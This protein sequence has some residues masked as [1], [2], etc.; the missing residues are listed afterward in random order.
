VVESRPQGAARLSENPVT[1][2]VRVMIYLPAAIWYRKRR[3]IERTLR[4][5][6]GE[7]PVS[8]IR[9]RKL[10]RQDWADRWKQD[11]DVRKVGRRIVIVPSWKSYAPKRNEIAITMDPG[12]AFG[13]GL[14]PTTRLCLI[15][16][17]KYLRIGNRVLDVGTGSGILAIAS[18][19]LGANSIDA[20]DIETAAIEAAGRNGVANGIADRTRLHLGTLKE[21][22]ATIPTADL[23]LVNILAYTIIRILPELKSKLPT[24][25]LLVTGG[26]LAEFR[27][28]VE[29]ALK[30]AGF[31][32]IEAIQEE[33][34]VTLIARR[35]TR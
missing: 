6:R 2:S 4:E 5:L 10:E 16:L 9:T 20:L 29:A 11:Y 8:E 35:S 33:D 22:G 3:P 1:S 17:E 23:V 21:L 26:I 31:D 13:T 32:V 12:M 15:A 18:A 30:Q 19:K 7:F 14:H 25:G 28:D 27:P 24:G 34:W